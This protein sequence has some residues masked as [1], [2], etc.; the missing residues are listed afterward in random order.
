MKRP[1]D[2][3]KESKG[4]VP[5]KKPRD[6]PPLNIAI[7]VPGVGLTLEIKGDNKTIVD[8]VNGHG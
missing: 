8:C 6:L 3:K 2:E 1:V 5:D 7:P 4:P